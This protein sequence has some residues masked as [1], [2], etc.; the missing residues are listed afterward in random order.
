MITVRNRK[1]MIPYSQR[2][3]AMEGDSGTNA[4]Q[5]RVDDPYAA[6]YDYKLDTR[7]GGS[8]NVVDLDKAADETGVTLTWTIGADQIA[9]GEMAVQLRAFDAQGLVWHTNTD[10][11]AV[12]ASLGVAGDYPPEALSEFSQIE[13]AATA[14]KTGA[15]QAAQEAA[16]S[17]AAAGAAEG[18][19]QASAQ[20]AA[21]RAS[22][23]QEAEANAKAS[24]EN[25][26]TAETTAS[27]A[28][29]DL[30]AALGVRVATLGEDG[31]LTPSQ[32]P[33]ISINDVFEVGGA[34]EMLALAAQ[35]GDCALVMSDGVVAD[36]YILAADD[37]AQG[38][39]WKKLGVS[40]VA[41]AGHA[42]TADTAADASRIN[43][44]RIVAMTAEQYEA[45]VKDPDTLYLVSEG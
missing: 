12:G 37:P 42:G 30:L 38:Y 44:K 5:I 22:A 6:N 41:N 10:T 28:L 24:E 2:L 1:L 4:L 34:E 16:A 13:Q 45:A 11:V 14:A 31:R 29:A 33:A 25:S 18:A 23:A 32:I 3:V 40:Y 35:R 43:G 36:S 19:V 21:E 17:A 26:K 27:Q 7:I 20:E 15:R 39:N 9:A 8:G